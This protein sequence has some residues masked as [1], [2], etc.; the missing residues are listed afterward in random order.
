MEFTDTLALRGKGINQISGGERQRVVLARVLAQEPEILLLDEPMSH[1]DIAH[2][3]RIL[4][5]LRRLNRQ[6]RTIVL[7]AHD[8]NLAALACSR[9][10]LLDSGRAAACAVPEQVLQADLI[11][12]VYGVRPILQRHPE[13]GLPQL[14]LPG[15]R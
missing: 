12:R 15:A 2:Q 14:V 9:L 1:L 5:I 13:T 11:E 7:L 4:D 3:V 10:L 6:G 8:L